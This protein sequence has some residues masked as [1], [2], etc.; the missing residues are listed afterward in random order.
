LVD[1]VT[2]ALLATS[3]ILLLRFRFNSA[4]LVLGGA[5]VGLLSSSLGK[6]T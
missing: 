3:L 6:A 1:L 5:L 2:S 4:W